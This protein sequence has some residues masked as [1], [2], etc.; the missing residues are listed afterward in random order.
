M[1]FVIL[2]VP[3][4]SFPTIDIT[5]MNTVMCA[6]NNLETCNVYNTKSFSGSSSSFNSLWRSLTYISQLNITRDGIIHKETRFYERNTDNIPGYISSNS[7]SIRKSEGGVS[8]FF[9]FNIDYRITE[10]NSS[11]SEINEFVHIKL[12][13]PRF[14]KKIAV[15]PSPYHNI[16]T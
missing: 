12:Q 7:F 13:V 9:K 11:S 14:K 16:L 4:K 1:K 5:F 6:K 10:I 8:I 3:V 2:H 15:Y